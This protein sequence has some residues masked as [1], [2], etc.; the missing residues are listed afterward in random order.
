MTYLNIFDDISNWFF[1]VTSNIT[2]TGQV[3]PFIFGIIVGVVIFGL[4]Y[5]LTIVTRFKKN[6]KKSKGY[7]EIDDELGRLFRIIT[8][9]TFDIG[10]VNIFL[11]MLNRSKNNEQNIPLYL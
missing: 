1:R 9:V 2:F 3:I 4:L 5:V 8:A 6:E 10:D 7:V 11:T